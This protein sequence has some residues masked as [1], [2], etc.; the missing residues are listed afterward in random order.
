MDARQECFWTDA[1]IGFYRVLNK[2]ADYHSVVGLSRKE[3][4]EENT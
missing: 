2:T 3:R 1:V 4:N